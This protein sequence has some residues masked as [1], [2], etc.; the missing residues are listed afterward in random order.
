MLVISISNEAN[1]TNEFESYGA[2]RTDDFLNSK[3]STVQI[4][5]YYRQ[6]T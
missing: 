6:Y 4:Q 3:K 1:L 2:T 5:N